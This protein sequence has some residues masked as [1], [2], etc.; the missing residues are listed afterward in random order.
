MYSNAYNFLNRIIQKKYYFDSTV[1]GIIF[2]RCWPA[3][4]SEAL[5]RTV[6][7]CFITFNL[8]WTGNVCNSAGKTGKS[9]S[10]RD[11]TKWYRIPML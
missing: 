7:R 3:Q 8:K 10:F 9:Q 1:A 6:C 5:C 2:N 4:R 11:E